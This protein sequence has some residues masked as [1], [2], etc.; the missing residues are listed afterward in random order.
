MKRSFWILSYKLRELTLEKIKRNFILFLS[1]CVIFCIGIIVGIALERESG[2][3]LVYYNHCRKYYLNIFDAEYTFMKIVWQRFAG[4]LVV[5]ALIFVTSLSVYIFPVQFILFFYKGFLLGIICDI[6]IT[7]FG[8]SGTLIIVIITVPQNLW[9]FFV[10]A[11]ASLNGFE[12]AVFYRRLRRIDCLDIFAKEHLVYFAMALVAV[13]W[14]IL[15][16]FLIF[17]PL[18]FFV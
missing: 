15:I 13:I 8:V 4:A 5:F 2:V 14:E 1:L 16:V 10:M 3:N 7:Q 9:L 11:M 12:H 17:R 6:I 18:N